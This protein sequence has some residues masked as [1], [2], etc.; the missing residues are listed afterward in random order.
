MTKKVAGRALARSAAQRDIWQ[1]VLDGVREIKAGG[2]K[3]TRVAPNSPV[4]RARLNSGLT[5]TQFAR[6]SESRGAHWS[7]GSRAGA[8]QAGPPRHS[9]SWRNCIPKWCAKLRPKL[10]RV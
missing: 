7:N 1:E 4:V 2:G 9:S 5:Q 8:N 6:Y 3:R 10:G